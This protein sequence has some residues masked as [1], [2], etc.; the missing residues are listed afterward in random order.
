MR[1]KNNTKRNYI[2]SGIG[3][4]ILAFLSET[5]VF[6]YNIFFDLFG[7]YKMIITYGCAVLGFW[8]VIIGLLK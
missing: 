5:N 1:R 2:L 4:M 8:V 7:V 6:V 3:L